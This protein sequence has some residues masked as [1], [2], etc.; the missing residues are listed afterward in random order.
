MKK[1]V[2]MLLIVALILAVG[3]AALAAGNVY[4]EGGSTKIR[5]G[6][7]P[8]YPEVGTLFKGESV[9][10]LGEC[11]VDYR[12]VEWYRI[13]FGNTSGWV[14]SRYTTLYGGGGSAPAPQ[15][16]ETYAVVAEDGSA[17]VRTGPGLDYADIGTL[18]K[19]TS[20]IYMNESRTDSRGVA[21]YRIRYGGGTGWVSSKYTSLYYY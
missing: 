21:W 16:D 15:N 5:T 7:S 14:S 17:K 9:Y 19:G 6:P 2:T 18:L 20:A 3:T 12:G 13:R 1:V 8:D 4:A 10:Y 11:N